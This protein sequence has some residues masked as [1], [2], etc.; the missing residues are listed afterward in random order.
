MRRVRVLLLAG[1]LV[2]GS[3]AAGSAALPPAS[4]SSAGATLGVPPGWSGMVAATPRC[5]PERLLVVSSAP[6]RVGRGGA[7]AAPVDGQVLVVLLEDRYRVDRPVGDLRRPAHFTVTWDHLTGL[8]GACDAPSGP[9]F[10]RYFRAHGR[11]IGFIVFPG[12]HLGPA[13]RARTLQ[14]MDSLRVSS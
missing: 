6:I 1:L 11:Y 9:A 14:V 10:M 4:I 3:A 13:T 12:A 2:L 5:D 8:K 7:L